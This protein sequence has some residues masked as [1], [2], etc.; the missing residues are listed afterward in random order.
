VKNIFII[1]IL[2]SIWTYTFGQNTEL[3]YDELSKNLESLIKDQKYEEALEYAVKARQLAKDKF[4][5]NH[6]E[7]LNALNNLA[8][9]YNNLGNN[10]NALPLSIEAVNITEKMFGKNHAFLGKRLNNLACVY[11]EL[12]LYEQAL[13]LFIEALNVNAKSLGKDHANYGIILNN[14]EGLYIKMGLYEQALPLTIKI[15]N[16]TAISFGKD[17]VN[18]SERLNNLGLLYQSMGL[19]D[20]ALPAFNE[21]LD[22]I[23]R[24]LGKNHLEYSIPLNNLGLLYQS[25]GLYDQALPIFIE[26]LDI[27]RGNL[28]KNHSDY[29]TILSNLANLYNTLGFYDKALPLTIEALDNTIKSLGK[30]HVDYVIRLNNLSSLYQNMGLYDKALPFIIESVDVTAR[31]LGKNHPDYGTRLNNLADIYQDMGLYDKA[32][33]LIIEALD[34]TIMSLGKNHPDYLIRLNNLAML[35]QNIGLYDKAL[36]LTIE[37]LDITA[38]ILGKNHPDYGVRLNNL[39]EIYQDMGL[40]NKVLPLLIETLDVTSRSLGKN[41]PNYSIILNNLSSLYG[42]MGLYD[43]ALP[44]IIESVDVT[45]RIL[46]K[47]HPDYGNRLNNLAEMYQNMGLYD[48]VLPILLESVDVTSRSLGKNHPEY[49]VRLNNLGLLYQNM[50]LYD[51]ALPILLESVVVTSKSLGKNH[52]DCG[53]HVNNLAC[54]YRDIGLYDQALLLFFEALDVIA[55]SLGKEHANYGLILNNLASLYQKMGL[56]NQALPLIIEAMVNNKKNILEQFFF[57]PEKEKELYTNTI[58]SN[59]EFYQSF[60]TDYSSQNNLVSEYSYNLSLITKSMIL[61][62]ISTLRQ[63]I[64]TN[65]D[66]LVENKFNKWVIIKNMIAKEH[67]KQTS[68]RRQD[69]LALED[70]ANNIERDLVEMSSTFGKEQNA[71]KITWKDV[72]NNLDNH[73]V[74]IEFSSFR[75]RSPNS[76]TDSIL[77]VALILRANDLH[78]EMVTLCEQKQLDSIFVRTTNRESSQVNNTYK[79]NRLYELIWKPIEKHVMPGDQIYFSPSG[80]MHQISIDAITNIDSTYL[81]DLYTFYPVGSTGILASHIEGKKPVKDV[82]VFGGI[83]FDASDEQIASAAK[84]I[85]LGDDIVSRSL[86]TQDSTRS[87]KWTYLIGT[88]DEAKSIDKMAKSKNIQSQLFTGAKAIEERFK[89]L[90]GIQSPSVIHIATHGFFFPDPKVDKKKLEMIPFQHDNTFTLADNPMNRSGL[91]FAGG[92]KAWI[93]EELSTDREDGILTAYEVSNMSLFNTELV[94]LSACETGLGDIKGSEGVYGLQRAFKQAGVR[95]LMMSLWKVPD[96]ATKEFMITFYTEYLTNQKPV[97][98]AFN[99]T[100]SKMKKKY[101][102][103]PYKWGGFVLME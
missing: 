60:Y 22:I 81:S 25:M 32:L 38:R 51:K 9:L 11:R 34:N 91:L 100:Q 87:G 77:Y 33:P 75:Y 26:A 84:D 56:Y 13:P 64:N 53:L 85:V 76:W 79:N 4:G 29:G 98:E 49:G 28:G 103:E 69:F 72:Q 27:T 20:Q 42:K 16:F 88:M 97:R 23:E 82:A 95:Y 59:F 6:I 99:I 101:R 46:G 24:N 68:Q 71:S 37:V 92:N 41:H 1:I 86:Y 54:L 31:I 55:I 21:A 10:E 30:N 5:I 43:K 52:P 17:H 45:A 70:D 67:S 3:G 15:L 39:A 35:Y 2:F 58:M 50:G 89:S 83:D 73:E 40:Y 8:D 96:N 80:S 94:V 66:T 7:Y 36:P 61:N 19:Y 78:P 18:Y 12:G 62:S 93:G 44:L 14:L 102:N 63:N 74:A 57:L 48:K 90:S 47:N 65:K